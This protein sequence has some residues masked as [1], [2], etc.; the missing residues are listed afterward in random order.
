MMDFNVTANLSESVKI[1]IEKI[2]NAVGI[3]YDPLGIKRGKRAFVDSLYSNIINDNTLSWQEK[4][5]IINECIL[6]LKKS[7]NRS[8]IINKAIPLVNQN[9]NPR[10][11]DD[12]WILNFLDKS[13]TVSE[14]DMQIIWSRI[15]AEEAN[16]PNTVSKRLLHNLA[17]MSKKDALNFINLSKFCF[18]DKKAN[19]VHPI[20]FI[21]DFPRLYADWNIT[22][23]ILNELDQFFLIETNY[24]NNFIFKERKELIYTNCFIE[25]YSKKI[26]VGNV[27][28]TEDGQVLFQMIDKLNEYKIL[29][30]IISVWEN[31]KYTVKI[32]KI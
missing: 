6:V 12:S 21:K 23:K 29:E 20:I 25:V 2:S 8:D 22:T 27:R 26:N 30:F 10:G 24:D 32:N 17:L 13:G 9:A 15:L 19:L 7:K 4:A 11:I 1:L 14:E 5:A 16:E 18:F 31:L 28:F 3:L